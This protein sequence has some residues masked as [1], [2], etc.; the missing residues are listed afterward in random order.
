M[1]DR[2]AQHVLVHGDFERL[3][4]AV[5][6]GQG[7]AEVAAAARAYLAGQEQASAMGALPVPF[8]QLRAPAER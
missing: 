1:L 3:Q 2:A 5:R 7:D 6:S 4:A 8:K